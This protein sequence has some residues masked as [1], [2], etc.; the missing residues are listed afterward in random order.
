MTK[1][2]FGGGSPEKIPYMDDNLLS[3]KVISNEHQVNYEDLFSNK[4]F[5]Y[6]DPT[7]V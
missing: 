1:Y 7:G 3:S 5:V 4:K 2:Y 6:K